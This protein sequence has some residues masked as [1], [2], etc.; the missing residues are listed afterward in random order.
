[1][2]RSRSASAACWV[3]RQHG[4][5]SHFHSDQPH[6]DQQRPPQHSKQMSAIGSQGNQPWGPSAGGW[7]PATLNC[8]A[9]I[10]A[11]P[12]L[13]IQ[14]PRILAKMVVQAQQAFDVLKA[15]LLE[16]KPHYCSFH[17]QTFLAFW[18][19]MPTLTFDL[20]IFC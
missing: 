16:W 12:I 11:M 7:A 19:R 1:M 18:T 2:Q 9:Y 5:H 6:S 3:C 8:T 4:C 10:S 15:T 13:G 14:A 17:T 20:Y